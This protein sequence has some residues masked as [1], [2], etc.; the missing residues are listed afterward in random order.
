MT[1]RLWAADNGLKIDAACTNGIGEALQGATGRAAYE[2]VRSIMH[3]ASVIW[4]PVWRAV[5]GAAYDKGVRD[6]GQSSSPPD[7]RHL[8]GGRFRP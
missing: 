2:A 8:S 3:D 1:E 6:V 7:P 4:L 5:N